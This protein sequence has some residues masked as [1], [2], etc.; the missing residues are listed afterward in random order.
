MNGEN[1]FHSVCKYSD[2]EG[3]KI[4]ISIGFAFSFVHS[5]VRWEINGLKLNEQTRNITMRYLKIVQ[6]NPW[7]CIAVLIVM[8]TSLT[9]YMWSYS[10]DLSQCQI[11]YTNGLFFQ[12]FPLWI[13]VCM[14]TTYSKIHI[15]ML[16][17]YVNQAI[18]KMRVCITIFIRN[19]SLTHV[20]PKMPTKNLFMVNN[21]KNLWPYY[22]ALVHFKATEKKR[23]LTQDVKMCR[24]I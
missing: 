5:F 7:L 22:R 4:D 12:K 19:T 9:L 17:I 1:F 13:I 23:F 18:H 2:K 6:S 24:L 15:S 21:K 20:S 14:C 10:N 16:T 8:L 11:P 3:V